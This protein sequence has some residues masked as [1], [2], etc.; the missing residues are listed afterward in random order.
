MKDY[1]LF[2]LNLFLLPGEYTQLYIFEERY[3]QLI[4]EVWE[5]KSS[6]GIPF[7][8]KLNAKNLGTIVEVHDVVS[9]SDEGEMEIVVR[10]VGNF[11]LEK[12]YYQLAGKLYPA[13]DISLLSE[14]TSEPVSEPLY[15][16]FREYLVKHDHYDIELLARDRFA[17][18]ELPGILN[19]NDQEKME[20]VSL[21]GA[22]QMD[23]YLR[24]YL[25][26]LALLHEQESRQFQNIY[27]N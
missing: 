6:F 9:R 3:K 21:S 18:S 27:L 13:G 8:N 26:Y 11:R 7:S 2:P 23:H 14:T 17:Y 25:R 12:F 22:E 4:N 19:F 5:A 15:H 24:N 20:F 16:D 10:A 1:P